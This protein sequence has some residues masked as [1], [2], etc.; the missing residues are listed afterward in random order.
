MAETEQQQNPRPQIAARERGP[1]PARYALP[2]VCGMIG[3]D[4]R[5]YQYPSYTFGMKLGSSIFKKDFSP[6]P[7]H[8]IDPTITRH[9]KDG[10]PQYSLYSRHKGF[11]PFKTPGPGS[12]APERTHPQNEKHAPVYSM[13]ARTRYRKRDSTPSPNTYSLPTMLGSNVPNNTSAASYS[14]PGRPKTGGFVSNSTTPGANAYKVIE[15]DI[16][17]R[18][19]PSYGLYS[20]NYMPGDATKK[21][22]PGAHSPEKVT[23]NKKA[24]P[25][26]TMGV[27]HS[28]YLCPLIIDVSD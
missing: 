7:A 15:P 11:D 17:S 12:Y 21:P 25:S 27:R 16:T 5:R 24:Q 2:T 13:S 18:K 23:V 19:A 1:G 20:R 22:G 26:Y 14:F 4:Q 9:G 10:T 3:H 28:E 6:G 8:F